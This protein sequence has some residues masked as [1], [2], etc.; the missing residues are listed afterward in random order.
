[1]GLARDQHVRERGEVGHDRA[2][3]DVAAHGDFHWLLRLF[4]FRARQHVAERDDRAHLV[5]HLD[6]DRAAPGYG[7]EDAHVVARHRVRDL[8]GE[9][10]DLVDLD[11]GREFEFVTRHG[12][13]DRRADETR[14]DTELAHRRFEHFAALLHETRVDLALLALLQQARGR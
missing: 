1:A 9:A 5:G 8:F 13:S 11:T 12:R 10:G 6:P 4:R 3:L 2:T 7:R 14:V